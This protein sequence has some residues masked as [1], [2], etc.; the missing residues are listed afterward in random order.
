VLAISTFV[1]T[2]VDDLLLL[3]LYFSKHPNKAK[4]IVIGQ[5]L[6][7]LCLVVI[8]LCASTLGHIIVPSYINILGIIPILIGFKDL[9]Q[10]YY[11]R[12]KHQNISDNAT[13]SLQPMSV[14]MVTFANGGDNIGVYTPLFAG[15]NV[16]NIYLYLFIFILMTGLWCLFAR[17]LVRHKRLKK[18]FARYGKPLLPFFLIILG[19][20]ILFK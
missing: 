7:I 3:S 19:L 11:A 6:G 14:A 18:H 4:Q 5:Y 2:N 10:R 20:C 17:Y 8:S 13:G 1:I 15:L 9:Y 12:H 16:Y